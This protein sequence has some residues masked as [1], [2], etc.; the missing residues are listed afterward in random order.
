[1]YCCGGDRAFFK[2]HNILPAEFLA[3]IARHDKDQP[4][5]DWVARRSGAAK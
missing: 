2:Q 1:M 5:V 3:L 4:I